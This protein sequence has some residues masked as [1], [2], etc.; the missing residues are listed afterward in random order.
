M[1]EEELAPENANQPLEVAAVLAVFIDQLAGVAWQKLGLQVDPMTNLAHKDLP[2]AQL[3]INALGDLVA[4]I[5]PKLDDSDKR[6]LQSLLTDLR[7]N[8]VN[9]SK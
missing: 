6:Q 9:Q 5:E 1:N 2:E 7:I 4:R 8:F 3:A